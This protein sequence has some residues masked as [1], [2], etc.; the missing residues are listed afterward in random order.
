VQPVACTPEFALAFF[1]FCALTGRFAPASQGVNI[2]HIGKDGLARFPFPVPPLAEQ[3]RIVAKLDA[4]TARTA[5]ARAELDRVPL[6]AA[7]YKQALLAAAF[8]G[9][10]TADWRS[11]S[12]VP[13]ASQWPRTSIGEL[14]LDIRYGTAAKCDY[15]PKATPVLRIPNVAGG[16]IDATDI[17]FASFEPREIARL[18]LQDGDLLLIRS[19]GSVDLVGR[20]AVV[21][22]DVVG[23]L[24]AGYL[25]RLR[26][27]RERVD[28]DFIHLAFEEPT[29]RST[30]QGLAKSTSGVNNINSEQLRGLVIPVPSLR[31]QQEIVRRIEGAFAEIDRLAAEA[32]AGRRLLD[33]L[34]QSI[35]AKAFRGDLVPQDPADEPASVLLARIR[36][37]RG[38]AK[39]SSNR[40]GRKPKVAA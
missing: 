8:R 9:D 16:R 19:N 32:A 22:A 36:A 17:K 14:A 29:I 40:R 28:P 27:D 34:D 20:T 13:E 24:F 25:I 6:L 39:T 5:S 4:L 30:I 26:M 12:G 37:E 21:K 7:R 35:L 1:R 10:L 2:A 11:S 23:Y 38:D 3:R 15:E 33:R 18:A 31:E